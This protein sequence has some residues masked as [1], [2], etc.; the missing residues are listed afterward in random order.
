MKP[1]APRRLRCTVN[2]SAREAKRLHSLL[3]CLSALAS[4]ES[5]RIAR[6]ESDAVT[7]SA[8]RSWSRM[9]RKA[10]ALAVQ[11]DAVALQALNGFSGPNSLA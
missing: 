7:L 5:D 1:Y 2:L 8:V 6:L 10:R 9:S 4:N 11:F 3:R